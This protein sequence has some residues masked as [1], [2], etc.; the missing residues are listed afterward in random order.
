M[1]DELI[2][3]EDISAQEGIDLE[4]CK[5][6]PYTLRQAAFRIAAESHDC[7]TQK[8]RDGYGL[9]DKIYNTTDTAIRDL[10]EIVEDANVCIKNIN[11]VTS[12]VTG[13]A[14][15]VKV[16]LSFFLYL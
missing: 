10:L 3:L 15:L 5:K 9:I 2:E 16:S 11:S 4:D 12:A 14:C 6:L 8:I 7:I 1:D 13:S